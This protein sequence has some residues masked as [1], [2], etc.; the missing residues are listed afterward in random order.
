MAAPIG[1][2]VHAQSMAQEADAKVVT[3]SKLVQ[4]AG[5]AKAKS[6]KAQVIAHTNYKT[7]LDKKTRT[8]KH[9]RHKHTV[10]IT[11]WVDKPAAVV[12]AAA[13]KATAEKAAAEKAAAEQ[14]EREPALRAELSRIT[15]ELADTH[16]YRDAARNQLIELRYE[17]F[18]TAER[19]NDRANLADRVRR[20]REAQRPT[21][22]N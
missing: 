14:A 22:G 9:K 1:A 16:A 20:T 13:E 6:T 5:E 12:D 10:A 17:P 4:Q 2:S 8:N 11:E 7:V 19:E 21:S 18:T 15:I 3:A